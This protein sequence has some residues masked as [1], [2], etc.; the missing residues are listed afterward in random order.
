MV[1]FGTWDWDRGEIGH[2]AF[3][4][5]PSILLNVST[6]STS[7]VYNVLKHELKSFV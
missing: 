6:T 3:Y 2:G 1:I 7:Y 5:C 4:L